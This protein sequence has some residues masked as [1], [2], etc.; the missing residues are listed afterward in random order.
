M[1]NQ[2]GFISVLIAI[3]LG[4]IVLGG[5][6][7]FVMQQKSASQTTSNIP[8]ATI[9]TNIQAPAQI[10]TNT[11]TTQNPQTK[12]ETQQPPKQEV[13]TNAGAVT[14]DSSGSASLMSVKKVAAGFI[15][16]WF[17]S[18]KTLPLS[19]TTQTQAA[20][21]KNISLCMSLVDTNNVSVTET[22][23]WPL[24][25]YGTWSAMTSSDMNLAPDASRTDFWTVGTHQA[26]VRFWL[27]P[28]KINDYSSDTTRARHPAVA[29]DDTGIFQI[30]IPS[31]QNPN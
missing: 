9:P 15:L 5:G 4:V 21:P 16:N 2:R 24:N 11:Q 1:Q 31:G 26:K 8:D 27:V 20:D 14:T 13:K 3:L 17:S 25:Q 29:V 18:E 7:Y 6:V 10:N 30:Y 12:T 19:V 22:D 23:C 28:E